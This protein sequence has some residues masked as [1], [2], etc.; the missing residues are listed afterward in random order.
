MADN[1]NLFD[2]NP[3]LDAFKEWNEKAVESLSN[4]PFASAA[5]APSFDFKGMT[6][7]QRRNIEA[8]TEANQVI[9]ESIQAA[10]RRQAEIAQSNLGD[11]LQTVKETL[12]AKT[13][14][15]SA[16]QSSDLAKSLF[17]G[18]LSN[19]SETLEVFTKSSMEAVDII[20]KRVSKAISEVGE[21]S[22]QAANDA[23]GSK[24]K[25]AA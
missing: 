23:A 5:K 4:N 1:T 2:K 25:K 16:N 3:F 22:N 6:E 15:E 14:E 10:A 17:E 13:P 8:I 19:A 21:I 20:N 7:I 9:G 24:K 11:I 12:S 18:G